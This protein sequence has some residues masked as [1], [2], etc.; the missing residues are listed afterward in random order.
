MTLVMGFEAI[1]ANKKKHVK[2]VV[3]RKLY[4]SAKFGRKYNFVIQSTYK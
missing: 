4:F 2:N 1:M 3:T